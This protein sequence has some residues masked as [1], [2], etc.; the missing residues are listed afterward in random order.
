MKIHKSNCLQKRVGIYLNLILY[1]PL[2]VSYSKFVVGDFG[3]IWCSKKKQLQGH[4]NLL[5]QFIIGYSN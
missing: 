5:E 2:N 1:F 4:L 3:N